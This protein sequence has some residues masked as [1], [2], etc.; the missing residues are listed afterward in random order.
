ML[1]VIVKNEHRLFVFENRVLR[2]ISG[3]LKDDVIGKLEDYI[4][5][6]LSIST[7]RQTF[8]R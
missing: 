4:T 2:N 8:F 1:S 6:S 7:A 3:P 5:R